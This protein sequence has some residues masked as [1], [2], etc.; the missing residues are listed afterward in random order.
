MI[1]SL[2]MYD[3]AETAAANDRLWKLIHAGLPADAPQALCRHIPDL[4]THWQSPDLMLSQ[5]CG[6]PYRAGLSDKVALV[7]TPV[8]NLDCRA[9]HYYSVL[10]AHKN[11]TGSPLAAF[12]GAT[13]AYNDPLSQ[14][15]W[16][17][18]YHHMEDA[19]LHLGT[20]LATGAHLASALAVTEGRAD[21]AAID[22]LTWQMISKWDSIAD[23][24]CVIDTTAPTPALPY[25]C[26]TSAPRAAMLRALQDAI[27]DLPPADKAC[28]GIS[29]IT[30]LSPEAYLAVK[31]PPAPQPYPA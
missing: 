6:F 30:T 23:A 3:R 10:I 2:P 24:L 29:D 25:I 16:A 8:L 12:D 17:A 14:S 27:H 7:A 20:R 18:L 15:G 31:T 22:A 19:G 13:A 21:I 9:G 28:L 11:R 4:M 1:A 5:T 26:S